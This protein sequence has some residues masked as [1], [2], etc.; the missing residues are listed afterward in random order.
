MNDI[1]V[2]DVR[3]GNIYRFELNEPR[4][5]LLLSGPLRDK[6]ADDDEEF[7]EAIFGHDFE[8]GVTD[9][10]VGPDGMLY[11]VSGAWADQGKIHRI[12]PIGD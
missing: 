8:G 9:L 10:E 4:T 3:N 1:F 12:I 5:Q 7:E 6:V 2:G 11:V